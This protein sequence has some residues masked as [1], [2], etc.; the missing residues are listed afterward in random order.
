MRCITHNRVCEQ[1]VEHHLRGQNPCEDCILEIRKKV[2]DSRKLSREEFIKRAIFI[3][4]TKY[5]Y[6][7]FMYENYISPSTIKC[8]DCGS[9][10]LQSPGNHLVGKGCSGCINKTETKLFKYL[11]RIDTVIQQYKQYWCKKKRYLP[12]DCCLPNLKIIIELD[13]AQ[14]F[15]QVLNWCSNE[16]T[17]ANDIFKMK[18]AIENGYRVIRL[19]QEVA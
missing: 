14:H 8:N 3:H 17:R 15:Q 19:L 7:N 12:Y 5:V 6:D 1:T 18:C 11:E 4:G 10:F 2:V 13:G 9:I 16:K